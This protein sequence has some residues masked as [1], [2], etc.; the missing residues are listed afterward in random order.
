[1]LQALNY[2]SAQSSVKCKNNN[3]IETQSR[4]TASIFIIAQTWEFY[5]WM[6]FKIL[7]YQQ[8][9]WGMKKTWI[10]VNNVFYLLLLCIVVGSNLLVTVGDDRMAKMWDVRKTYVPLLAVKRCLSPEVY[11]PLFWSGILMAQE[12]CF[13]TLVYMIF[14]RFK[15]VNIFILV[16]NNRFPLHRV[17]LDNMGFTILIQVIQESSITLC[18]LEKPQFGYVDMS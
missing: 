12:C 4:E 9:W 16:L 18:V 13:A 10:T 6:F 3:S 8:L 1:M 17:G 7:I 15:S 11:W 2:N 5:F 14:W